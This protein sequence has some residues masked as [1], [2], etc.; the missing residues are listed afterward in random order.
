MRC[1]GEAQLSAS[2]LNIQSTAVVNG[3]FYRRR[4]MPFAQSNL[5]FSPHIGVFLDSTE[6]LKGAILF[7]I[8]SFRRLQTRVL[9]KPGMNRV[10][11]KRY[12]VPKQGDHNVP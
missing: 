7:E 9:Y 8:R 3:T 11:C 12:T 5:T 2:E 10:I 4:A 1:S 6:A